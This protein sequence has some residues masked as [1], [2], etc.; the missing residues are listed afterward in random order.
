MG[1]RVKW[2]GRKKELESQ[3]KGREVIY[4]GAQEDGVL[5]SVRASPSGPLLQCPAGAGRACPPPF[6]LTLS[7][8][9]LNPPVPALPRP[10]APGELHLTPSCREGPET[11]G[12]H[13]RK[14]WG[15]PSNSL[16]REGHGGLGS[17]ES[18]THET[19]RCP[20][21]VAKVTRWNVD[22]QR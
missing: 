2:E 9:G 18:C 6:P 19:Q 11:P 10:V 16:L 15:C 21:F 22:L 20:W 5:L 8:P 13:G 7:C 12:R 14:P 1:G 3:D 4:R 17:S